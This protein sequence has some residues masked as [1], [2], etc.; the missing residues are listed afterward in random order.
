[1][2]DTQRQRLEKILAEHGDATI[3]VSSAGWRDCDAF[4]SVA[5]STPRT[6][7]YAVYR[8]MKEQARLAWDSAEPDIDK[9]TLADWLGGIAWYGVHAL[10]L[11]DVVSAT[12]DIDTEDL[13]EVLAGRRKRA[14]VYLDTH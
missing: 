14:L 3:Y 5:A 6:A 11:A 13:L 9:R 2:I 10:P 4:V 8:A 12:D 1:M 7:E